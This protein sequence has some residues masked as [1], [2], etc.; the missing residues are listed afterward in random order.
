MAKVHMFSRVN[1]QNLTSRCS[2]RSALSREIH[3]VDSTQRIHSSVEIWLELRRNDHQIAMMELFG[4]R[5]VSSEE[6]SQKSLHRRT[7]SDHRTL[8]DR[9]AAIRL[10]SC[11][12]L[13]IEL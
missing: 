13:I 12:F 8:R 4:A 7:V 10:A 11:L 9:H 3:R 5:S 1:F 2:R 6:S